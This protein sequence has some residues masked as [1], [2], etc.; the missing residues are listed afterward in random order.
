MEHVTRTAKMTELTNCPD[1]GYSCPEW[2]A[3]VKKWWPTKNEHQHVTAW[4]LTVTWACPH[5]GFRHT[6]VNNLP[7]L[8]KPRNG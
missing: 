7:V 4:N 5:G 1:V 8:S 3:V 6:E 2:K